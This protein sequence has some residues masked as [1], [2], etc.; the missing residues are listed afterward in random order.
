MSQ[1]T[2]FLGDAP[3]R[4][5]IRL[6][7]LSFIVGLVLSALNIHPLDIYWWIERIVLRIYDMGF[8]LFADALDYLILGALIVVPLFLLARLF[9][10]GGGRR[11]E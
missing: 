7:V 8:A 9:K 10:L 1:L 5:L 3:L 2:R 11:A 6:L 4:V